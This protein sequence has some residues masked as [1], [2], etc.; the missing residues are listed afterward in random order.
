MS[1][2]GVPGSCSGSLSDDSS[3]Q[4]APKKSPAAS[5]AI[6]SLPPR[7][8]RLPGPEGPARLRAADHPERESE[9]A[10]PG[11]RGGAA[12]HAALRTPFP[13]FASIFRLRPST[14]GTDPQQSPSSPRKGFYFE[15]RALI[16]NTET[17]QIEAIRFVEASERLS[18]G[19][20]SLCGLFAKV[21]GRPR[22]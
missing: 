7:L 11:G 22:S 17:K 1:F 14:V 2:C 4:R 19:L 5:A 9:A 3:G 12:H 8:P 13:L 21:T 18:F 16:I 20:L 10:P 6:P 15:R